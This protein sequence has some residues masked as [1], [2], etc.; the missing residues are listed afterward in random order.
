MAHQG[1]PKVP[2]DSLPGDKE[3]KHETI[4]TSSPY[5]YQIEMK[6][7]VDGVMTRMPISYIAYHQGWQPNRLLRLENIGEKDVV[8]P[9]ITIN[10]KRN[11]RTLNDIVNEA[12]AGCTT[13]GEKARVLWEYQRTHRF[14]AC[15]FDTEASDA[16]KLYNV[17]GYSRCGN[18]AAVLRDL[19]REAVLNTRFGLP[20][21][22]SVAECLEDRRQQGA[23]R[24]A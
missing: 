5:T 7:A 3:K 2:W 10:D 8:N 19:W 16:V 4:I 23:S 11:W 24:A 21:G 9:W 13:D 20:V 6:G 22:H 14:H 17:Y 15:T 1:S 18:D 12:I